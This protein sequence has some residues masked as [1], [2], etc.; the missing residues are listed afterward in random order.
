MAIY[1]FHKRE[2]EFMRVV[3]SDRGLSGDRYI[4]LMALS[5]T[6]ILGTIPLGTYF[7]VYNAKKDVE[8]WKSWADTHS[9]YSTIYQFPGVIWKNDPNMAIG[10]EMF[11]WLLVACAFVFFAFFGLVDEARRHYRLVYAWLAGRI[12]PKV[13]PASIPLYFPDRTSST[14][15]STTLADSESGVDKEDVN[16]LN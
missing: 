1:T 4:R 10:L 15:D 13:P 16:S 11:R 6:E 12:A 7:I 14:Q 3:T 2:R 9:H 5:A 8:P